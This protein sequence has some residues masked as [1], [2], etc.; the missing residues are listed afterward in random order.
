M[1]RT[2]VES[3]QVQRVNFLLRT[4]AHCDAEVLLSAGDVLC[5]ERWYHRQCWD[6]PRGASSNALK[7]S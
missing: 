3:N 1:Q 2:F 4:C 6:G 7:A 5:G